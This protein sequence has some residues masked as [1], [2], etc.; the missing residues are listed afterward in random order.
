MPFRYWP[1]FHRDTLLH[2]EPRNANFRRGESFKAETFH[3]GIYTKTT[4]HI[5]GMKTINL[6]SPWVTRKDKPQEQFPTQI[7]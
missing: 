1:P 2:V 3:W 7:S 6:G 5:L 4:Y